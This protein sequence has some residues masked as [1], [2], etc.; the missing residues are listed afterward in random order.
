MQVYKI[1]GEVFSLLDKGIYM[2]LLELH[3]AYSNQLIALWNSETSSGDVEKLLAL[4]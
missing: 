4:P 1:K 3:S 2:I